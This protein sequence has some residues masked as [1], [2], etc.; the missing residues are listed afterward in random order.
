[1]GLL[2]FINEA[3]EKLFYH[4]AT[5][6]ATSSEDQLEAANGWAADAIKSH[7]N[8]NPRGYRAARVCNV[9]LLLVVISGAFAPD[10]GRRRAAPRHLPSAH[11]KSK[12]VSMT[13]GA[14]TGAASSNA[15]V[16]RLQRSKRHERI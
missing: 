8:N 4:D 6:A 11:P 15:H 14:E 2:S 12:F 9:L 13:C 3:G 7:V 10:G 1:M 16:V 5:A